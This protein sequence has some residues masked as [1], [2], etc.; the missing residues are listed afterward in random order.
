MANKAVFLD[1]DNT[2]IED[3]GYLSDPADVKLLPGAD[4]AIKSLR[5]GG[6]KIVVVTN[7]SGVARG[8]LT[9]ERLEEVHA[10][11]RR[12]LDERGATVDAIYYCPYLPDAPIDEYAVDSE[13]R[14]P[15]PGMLLQAAGEM[16]LDLHNSWAI[17][18]A[19]RDVEAG[20]RAG[21]RTVRIRTPRPSG[22]TNGHEDPVLA[23]FT[24]RNLVDA[25]RVVLREGDREPAETPPEEES[26]ERQAPPEPA[27]VSVEEPDNPQ[28]P[29]HQPGREE[30]TPEPGGQQSAAEP[31]QPTDEQW[32]PRTG[33]QAADVSTMSDSAVRREILRH[34]RQFVRSSE[35]EEFS[36]S[37]LFAGILQVLVF[38]PLLLCI[39]KM[40]GG[41]SEFAQAA[42]WAL[43]AILLQLM[44][45]TFFIMHRGK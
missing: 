18:D 6:Y 35:A 24:V 8:L 37:K 16:D 26:A 7:Q 4:L 31:S 44:A 45:L 38:M 3:P 9:E 23:D 36:L 27:H 14:K 43:L 30:K 22:S 19:P 20:R 11:L 33:S 13:L 15:R 40:L 21:C 17:G 39:W 12:R 32:S 28:P 10:E 42:V 1:R 29:S 41:E 34:L 2:I 25:A 5:Q